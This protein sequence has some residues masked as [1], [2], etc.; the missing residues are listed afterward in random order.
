[1]DVECVYINN[2]IFQL[3]LIIC[4]LPV[5]MYLIC[6]PGKK[7]KVE[8]LSAFCWAKDGLTTIDSCDGLIWCDKN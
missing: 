4:S 1:M 3:Y 7:M 6:G 2:Y 5:L 8:G